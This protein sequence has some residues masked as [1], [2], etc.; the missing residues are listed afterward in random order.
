ML[1]R[2]RKLNIKKALFQFLLPFLVLPVVLWSLVSFTVVYRLM[3]PESM[4]EAVDPS[5][6]LLP[7]QELSWKGAA[8]VDLRAWF[9]QAK[10]DAPVIFLCHGYGSNRSRVLSIAERLY[11]NG[12]SCVV[13]AF[14][15]DGPLIRVPSTLGWREATD[16]VS[17]RDELR[18]LKWLSQQKMGAWGADMGAFAG[19]SAASQDPG[20][21][22]LAIDCGF[23]SLNRYLNLRASEFSGGIYPAIGPGVRRIY[24]FIAGGDWLQDLPTLQADKLRNISMMVLVSEQNPT[25]GALFKELQQELR[26]G[27][28]IY[29]ARTRID[30]LSGPELKEYDNRVAGFFR[31]IN[32]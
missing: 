9:I 12:L 23:I 32:W 16:L 10:P 11:A 24:A 31:T 1:S 19:M 13:L 6:Y 20:F 26:P 8:G 2:R 28:V 25:C 30:E 14:R 5:A 15:G 21:Q 18:R 22:A 7:Y 29:L 27:N 17:A 3:H 4:A